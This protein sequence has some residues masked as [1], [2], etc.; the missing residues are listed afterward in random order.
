MRNRLLTCAILLLGFAICAI[1]AGYWFLGPYRGFGPETFVDIEHG[2]SSR[3][4]ARDLARHGV[5][6]SSWAFLAIR[7][8]H[9]SA[10]LQAGEYRFGSAAT[11]WGV[12][13]KI[14]RGDIFYE[15]LT[16]PEGSN[17]FDIAAALR[18]LHSIA[19]EAF[20]RVATDAN[21]IRDLDVR[22]PG[23][24][25][26]L[27]PSTYRITH[28][29]TAVRLC[30]MMTNDFRKAWI[31]IGGPSNQ[32]ETHRIV[33]VASMIEKETAIPEERPLVASV[34]YNRLSLGMPLQCDPTTVYAALLDKRY[35]GTIHKSDLASE[36]PY[37]TYTHAGLPP[38][39][40]CNP[41]KASLEA[42]LHPAQTDYLYFVARPDGSGRHTFSATLADH[43]KAVM[44]YRRVAIN[45]HK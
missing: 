1:V 45:E 39:P 3:A 35:R 7:V 32:D 25:G 10:T 17:L 38:G 43:L 30:R 15:N 28:T 11:P 36:N 19:S 26:Y 42:A 4:I 44:A 18:N 22:A 37:N 29:T 21:G 34:F 8:L 41:G 5:V 40:I 12:F 20:L 6:R 23:L 33:V 14:S 2:M 16:V 24:E 9:P 31:S 27:F 13:E